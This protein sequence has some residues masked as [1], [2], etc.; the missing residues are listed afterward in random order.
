[1]FGEVRDVNKLRSWISDVSS[2]TV[3]HCLADLLLAR[4]P[5]Q[6]VSRRTLFLLTTKGM[7]RLLFL[8]EITHKGCLAVGT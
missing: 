4:S 2:A 8:E 3:Q 1:M 6:S 7:R 5:S